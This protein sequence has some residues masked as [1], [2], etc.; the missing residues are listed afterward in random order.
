ML[1]KKGWKHC[2]IQLYCFFVNVT[3]FF[4]LKSYDIDYKKRFY[5]LIYKIDFCPLTHVALKIMKK[6]IEINPQSKKKE[7][8]LFLVLFNIVWCPSNKKVT[9]HGSPYRNMINWLS[10]WEEVGWTNLIGLIQPISQ[11]LILWQARLMCVIL[12]SCHITRVQRHNAVSFSESE[13][14]T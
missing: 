5:L 6:N 7:N 12:S 3:F 8:K 2:T 4:C 1:D 10:Q 14:Q 9:N 11:Q 13:L